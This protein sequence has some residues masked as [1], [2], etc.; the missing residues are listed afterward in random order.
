MTAANRP[1]Q[2]SSEL[3][4]R[5]LVLATDI[6][7]HLR[8][9]VSKIKGMH[10]LTGSVSP[11]RAVEFWARMLLGHQYT[12]NE[13]REGKRRISPARLANLHAPERVDR[14]SMQRALRVAIRRLPRSE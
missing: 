7:E 11:C 5:V 2:Q 14:V 9:T 10:R 13:G 4:G 8:G 12:E 1:Y 6:G 3:L